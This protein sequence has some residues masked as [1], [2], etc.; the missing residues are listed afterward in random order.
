[1]AIVV[2]ETRRLIECCAGI[3]SIPFFDHD[4]AAIKSDGKQKLQC[5]KQI[6]S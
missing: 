6:Q 1:M 2:V 3:E 5:Q 4:A